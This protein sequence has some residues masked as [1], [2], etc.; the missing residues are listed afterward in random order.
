MVV[1]VVLAA[2]ELEEKVAELSAELEVAR[3]SH[4][5]NGGESCPIAVT[6]LLTP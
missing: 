3:A 1:V 6:L 4:V 5:I 2:A